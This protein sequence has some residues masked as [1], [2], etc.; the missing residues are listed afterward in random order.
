MS[1]EKWVQKHPNWKFVA[2]ED[3]IYVFNCN[4]QLIL[5]IPNWDWDHD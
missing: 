3:V 5:M 2:V 4:N 1:L